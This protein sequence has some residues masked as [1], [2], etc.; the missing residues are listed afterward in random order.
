MCVEIYRKKN[1]YLNYN[2]IRKRECAV[3]Y[4]RENMEYIISSMHNYI[5]IENQ[6]LYL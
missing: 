2:I 4:V 3:Y 6:S 5:I 1:R